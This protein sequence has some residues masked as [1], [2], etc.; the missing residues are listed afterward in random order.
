MS[1]VTYMFTHTDDYRSGPYL[2]IEPWD[3]RNE[4]DLPEGENFVANIEITT[5]Y[6]VYH[7]LLGFTNDAQIIRIADFETKDAAT[8]FAKEQYY[9]YTGDFPF[10]V[11]DMTY[12]YKS[13]GSRKEIKIDENAM[14][15]LNRPKDID[16]IEYIIISNGSTIEAHSLNPYAEW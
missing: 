5:R 15:K 6:I 10:I 8:N 4:D 7:T 3:D 1:S 12:A 11:D 13:T 2:S 9:L 14:C 16:M